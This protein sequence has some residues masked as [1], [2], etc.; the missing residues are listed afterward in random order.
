MKMALHTRKTATA[1]GLSM[2]AVSLFG[3]FGT[4]QAGEVQ[5]A[6]A[7]NFTAPIQAIAAGFEGALAYDNAVL[8]SDV[9]GT[10]GGWQVAAPAPAAPPA[11]TTAA[12]GALGAWAMPRLKT[13][14][15]KMVDTTRA[16]KAKR[17][18]S[19]KRCWL[20]SSELL[21]DMMKTPVNNGFVGQNLLI[22][23]SRHASASCTLAR[24]RPNARTRAD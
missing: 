1:L 24:P 15:P 6:V 19:A 5:V 20:S 4:A 18:P 12:A 2:L 8:R 10:V 13:T 23:K 11:L 3:A 17:K 7:A 22:V 9:I 14:T 16:I 21:K